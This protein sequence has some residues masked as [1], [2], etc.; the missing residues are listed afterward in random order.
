MP[1]LCYGVTYQI[2]HAEPQDGVTY[3]LRQLRKPLSQ[4]CLI[5]LRTHLRRFATYAHTCLVQH[6]DGGPQL[7]DG[8]LCASSARCPCNFANAQR[9]CQVSVSNWYRPND[10]NHATDKPSSR[11]SC[12]GGRAF[13]LRNTSALSSSIRFIVPC[14]SCE[15]S[16]APLLHVSC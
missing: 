15:T 2:S 5:S 14:T 16:G 3:R 11:F 6:V 1:Q 9:R 8:N 4:I 7:H 12:I 10:L 13:W